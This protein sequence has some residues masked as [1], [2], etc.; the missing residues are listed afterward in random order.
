M[1]MLFLKFGADIAV[2]IKNGDTALSLAALNLHAKVVN[3]LI[4][5]KIALGTMP[6]TPLTDAL[7]T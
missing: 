2:R 7:C 4:L 1:R 6:L 5:K 3:V